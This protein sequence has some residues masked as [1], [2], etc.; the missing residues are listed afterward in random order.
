M[1]RPWYEHLKLIPVGEGFRLYYKGS[2]LWHG[3]NLNADVFKNERIIKRMK[4]A[5][6]GKIW[7][8][9]HIKTE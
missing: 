9:N 6:E 8:S 1:N 7:L 3:K 2:A 5:D 4:E